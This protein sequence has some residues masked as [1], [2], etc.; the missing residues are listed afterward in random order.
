[1]RLV[2]GLLC[3]SLAIVC[4]SQVQAQ[5]YPTKP[6]RIWCPTPPAGSSTSRPASS[7]RSS[8]SGWGQQVIVE[9]R[10][11]GNGFI[12]TTA[13][14]KAAADGYTLLTAHTGEFA[15]SPAVFPNV[16]FDLERDFE[17]ITMSASRPCWSR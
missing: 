12:G 17:T 16:P 3:A 8:R 5:S 11:G 9:N 13:G 6:I 14:A 2:A 15:V 10:A 1:M 7:R 4:S